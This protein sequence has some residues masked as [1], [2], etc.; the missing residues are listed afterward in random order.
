MLLLDAALLLLVLFLHELFVFLNDLLL[1][2]DVIVVFGAQRRWV[3]ELRLRLLW[4]ELRL[5]LGLLLRGLEDDLL[6]LLLRLLGEDLL[7]LLGLLNLLGG[8]HDL[9][10]W[11]RLLLLLRLRKGES[12]L[13]IFCTR[14][15]AR[16]GELNGRLEGF[17]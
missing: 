4:G 14:G 16:I 12:L 9:R 7:W 8:L 11:L 5:E 15:D 13:I 10:S 1:F 3:E 17:L 2:A 6:L